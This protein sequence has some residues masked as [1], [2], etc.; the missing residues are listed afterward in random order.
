[1]IRR[2]LLPVFSQPGHYL[3]LVPRMPPVPSGTFVRK[4][5]GWL[6]HSSP[7]GDPPESLD[8]HDR[9]IPMGNP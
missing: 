5:E 7:D 3:K 9:Y 4:E 2:V 1:V 6:V 8:W